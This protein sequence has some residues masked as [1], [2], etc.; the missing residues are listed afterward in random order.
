MLWDIRNKKCVYELSTG[1]NVV[2][3]L[4]WDPKNATL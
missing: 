1:N 3:A 2:S 4:V